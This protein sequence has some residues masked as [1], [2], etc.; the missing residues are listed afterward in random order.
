[1]TP[2]F[3][4]FLTCHGTYPA[5]LGGADS[6]ATPRNGRC[7]SILGEPDSF[8][9]LWPSRDHITRQR[10]QYD[11]VRTRESTQQ[12]VSASRQRTTGDGPFSQ[13]LLM[14][15]ARCAAGVGRRPT[16]LAPYGEVPYL[17]REKMCSKSPAARLG[18]AVD[19]NRYH[20]GHQIIPT[21]RKAHITERVIKPTR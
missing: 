16:S 6:S 3:A 9:T 11:S 1:M 14:H 18:T 8:A 17:R 4:G 19:T 15:A 5:S 13:L 21:H 10:G 7:Y 2:V 12:Q 20:H